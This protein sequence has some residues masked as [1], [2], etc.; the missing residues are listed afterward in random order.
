MV[1]INIVG[2]NIFAQGGTTRSN[3]NLMTEFSKHHYSTTYY[4]YVDFDI[5]DLRR[6]HKEEQ[7]TKNVQIKKVAELYQLTE[8]KAV[9]KEYFFITREDLFPLAAVIRKYNLKALI[10][11]EVHTPL[12]LLKKDFANIKLDYFTCLRVATPSIKKTF[13]QKYHFDRIYVQTVSL[14]HLK[15]T[16]FK[17]INR[18]KTSNLVVYARFDEKAKDISY[19]ISL[20]T[21]L[22]KKLKRNDI[23]LYIKGYGPDE[24][25][26]RQMIRQAH[27]GSSIFIN[28]GLPDDY[29]ALSTAHVE[30]LG[31]TIA[32]SVA[33]GHRVIAYVGDDQVVYENFK[34]FPL[35][36]WLSKKDISTDAAKIIAAV[37]ENIQEEE[38]M[39]S[40]KLLNEMKSAY[41]EKMLQ[42][43]A[44]FSG[45]G[46]VSVGGLE[47]VEKKTK[48]RLE[49]TLGVAYAPWYLKV[50]RH[51]R[52]LP[53]LN[54]LLQ[55]SKFS[56]W[57]R[58]IS[59]RH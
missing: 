14:A 18:N 11:G 3:L 43:T 38:L 23:K 41:T 49:K 24:Q 12:Q 22:I 26:Y 17:N 2:Y 46:M 9:E 32:E 19:A 55:A 57:L 27:L 54:N 40:I 34:K 36:S 51:L 53:I 45:E 10:I 6:L 21:Y 28:K 33:Q 25:C 5:L 52:R 47:N 29:I 13:A 50:Y 7:V 58:T 44:I 20:V 37:T 4:N 48:E 31:Y 59:K 1:K 16:S 42:K 8:K 15:L 35:V 39:T 30:T 56:E